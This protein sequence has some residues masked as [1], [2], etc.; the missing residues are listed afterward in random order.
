MV[1]NIGKVLSGEWGYVC[2]DMAAVVEVAGGA[3]ALVK[4]IL[5]NCYLTDEQKVRLCEICGEVGAD[6][7]KTS[8]GYGSGGATLDDVRLMRRHSPPRVRVKAAGGIRDLDTLLEYRAA[9]AVRIGASRTAEILD[10]CR[11]RLG[12]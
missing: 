2:D 8:T 12:G 7:V 1:V 3:K 6:F 9:G 11:R 5:E 10:E 4:V